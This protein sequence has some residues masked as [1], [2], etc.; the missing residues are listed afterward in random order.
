MKDQL[1][2]AFCDTVTVREV[3][4]GLAVSTTVASVHGD[5]IG[6][7]V[8]GPLLDGKYRLEDSGLLVP[9]L[10]AIGADLDN[11]SRRETFT[12]LL[13]E[14]QAS[15]N[16]DTFEIVSEP[17]LKAE[18]P[19]ASLKFVTLLLRVADLSFMSHEKVA[20]TFKH[21]AAARIRDAV[22]DRAAVRE[23]EP[24]SAEVPDWE[25]DLVLEARGRD[26]V[27][28]FFVQTDTRILE[29]LMLQAE[30]LQ[31]NVPAAVI[32]LLERD[33]SVSK[34]KGLKARNRLETVPVYEGG[35]ADAIA[36]IA[37]EA[38]GRPST[39]H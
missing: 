39:V 24:L 17:V 11:E 5:P 20:S 27:A 13:D 34:S 33:N 9:Y 21:D 8:V 32:A 14:H 15:L 16:E 36:R 23:G 37:R 28:V 35:E 6:F 30:A 3:G 31:K 7:Y 29:A 26:P 4:A 25:P 1:C 19:A 2:K 18:V 22:G 10:Q 12:T 38:I